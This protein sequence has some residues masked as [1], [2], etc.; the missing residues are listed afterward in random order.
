MGALTFSPAN[1]QDIRF[2]PKIFR[3]DLQCSAGWKQTKEDDGI[4]PQRLNQ[5]SNY[6]SSTEK[7][8][9]EDNVDL[10]K[11]VN[12]VHEAGKQ[13]ITMEK[14]WSAVQ[15]FDPYESRIK[16][17][18]MNSPRK[19]VLSIYSQSHFNKLNSM[20]QS[21]DDFAGTPNETKSL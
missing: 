21:I 7:K 15:L 10:V 19:K 14:V 6:P 1:S 12:L 9:T 5:E 3:S 13:G 17:I 18:H 20:V 4:I 16:Y 8:Y 11:M 2:D